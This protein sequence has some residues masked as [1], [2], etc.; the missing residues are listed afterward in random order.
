MSLRVALLE[1]FYGG[2]HAQ[3]LDGFQKHSQHQVRPFTLPG[4]HWKW[5][6][7]GG[8]V[9]LAKDYL[10][11]GF[12]ADVILASDMLDLTTFLAL[13]RKHTAHIPT[14]IY[15]HENQLA[16][17]WSPTDAD[18]QLQRDHHYSFIN[19][20]SALAAD[21]LFFNSP[22]NRDSFL[23]ALPHFLRMYP[24][25]QELGTL[26]R[27]A[28]ISDILPLGMDL[29][30][31][32]QGQTA[33]APTTAPTI[34]WNHRWEHDKGP[35]LFFET[36][37]DFS[38]RGIPYELIVLGE[39]Y[40]KAPPI[41]AKAKTALQEHIRHWG[42]APSRADYA[43]WL[44]QADILP[45]TARQDFFGGSV[46]EAMYCGVRPLLPHRLAYAM[47]IPSAHWP[48]Y[49][50]HADQDFAPRLQ[51]LLQNFQP[52]PQVR[53]WAA[54]YDW[55]ELIPEYDDCLQALTSP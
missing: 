50:Y 21:A 4:R 51:A 39:Q 6:M 49:F 29:Q 9:T 31:L 19:Y 44:W 45:V 23:E 13:T 7:H 26:K 3:W 24:D 12:Q 37:I 40:T 38:Q 30:P 46:V 47:H 1:P 52:T 16:Y 43:H 33:K 20:S 17:P 22:D 18:P 53:P 11:S 35:D 41:F 28:T 55:S 36:L 10:E 15:F 32:D 5:R 14:A 42:Y 54:A 27:L 8:A 25:A 48:E 34:L 2:S